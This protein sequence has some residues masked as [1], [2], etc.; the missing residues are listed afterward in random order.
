MAYDSADKSE[1]TYRST[2][3][4][5]KMLTKLVSMYNKDIRHLS[6][7]SVEIVTKLKLYYISLSRWD[8]A[9]I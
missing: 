4:G 6:Y 8:L 7:A 2:F 9:T 3:S 5:V 1:M